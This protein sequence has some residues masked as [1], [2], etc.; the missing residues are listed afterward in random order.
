MIEVHVVVEGKT[1]AAYVKALLVEPFSKNDIH[2][3]PHLV[4]TSPLKKDPGGN[5]WSWFKNDLDRLTRGDRRPNVYFTY[6]D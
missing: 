3:H 6:D 1:E 4:R 5:K 2:L